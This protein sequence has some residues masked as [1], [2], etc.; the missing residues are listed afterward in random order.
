MFVIELVSGIYLSLWA[1]TSRSEQEGEVSG[2]ATCPEAWLQL[3][4]TG[5]SAGAPTGE[6][7]PVRMAGP[8]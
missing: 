7:R 6:E 1:S 8:F 3:P 5:A 2:L 4:Q